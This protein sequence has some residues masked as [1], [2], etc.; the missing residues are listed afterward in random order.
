MP[1]LATA[2]LIRRHVPYQREVQPRCP[3]R[4]AA[5]L[6]FWVAQ[7]IGED[8]LVVCGGCAIFTATTDSRPEDLLEV[9]AKTCDDLGHDPAY[10]CRCRPACT[11]NTDLPEVL[12]SLELELA[13]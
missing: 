8:V 7:D 1:A 5:E 3:S 9:H 2:P 10:I 6:A 12:P 13:A 11:I 4:L